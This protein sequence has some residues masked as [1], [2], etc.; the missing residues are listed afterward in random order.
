MYNNNRVCTVC[1]EACGT[2]TGGDSNSCQKC[3]EGWLL[4]GTVCTPGC[5]KGKYLQDKKCLACSDNCNMCSDSTNCTLCASSYFLLNKQCTQSC[6]PGTI[7]DTT[8]KSCV[9]CNPACKTC[10]DST[11]ND[12]PTCADKFFKLGKGCVSQC[13]SNQY[14]VGTTCTD[15]DATC[16]TC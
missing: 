5:V 14:T 3:N 6:P 11:S 15:C 9:S 13:N 8:S 7:A 10:N 1:N 16:M 12:C 4:I 2:C